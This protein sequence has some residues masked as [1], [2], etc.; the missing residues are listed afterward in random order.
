MNTSP[1]P[2][3]THQRAFLR[4]LRHKMLRVQRSKESFLNDEESRKA[5]WRESN[6]SLFLENEWYF[7]YS[8]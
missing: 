5:A 1:A 8:D 7:S 3:G 4:A 2:K 6:L